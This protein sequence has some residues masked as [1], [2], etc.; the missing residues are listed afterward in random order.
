MTVS[1]RLR[2][3]EA[4]GLGTCSQM[5]FTFLL[6]SVFCS[7]DWC[8]LSATTQGSEKACPGACHNQVQPW[9]LIPC[10]RVTLTWSYWLLHVTAPKNIRGHQR[11]RR[12]F[13]ELGL[14]SLHLWQEGSH[15]KAG[16][17]GQNIDRALKAIRATGQLRGQKRSVQMGHSHMSIPR[18]TI[19][20]K[21]M[22]D[23]AYSQRFTHT[24]GHCS[25]IYTGGKLK[26]SSL[27]VLLW[28]SQQTL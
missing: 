24:G 20:H 15:R 12:G 10:H 13:P 19:N 5:P 27:N 17:K 23:Q 4:G 6:L 21:E 26:M 11:P 1:Q 22:N 18:S 3:T 28:T 14:A 8:C 25:A 2:L 16:R 7:E 9:V